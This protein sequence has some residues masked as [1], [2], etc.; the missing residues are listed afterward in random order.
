LLLFLRFLSGQIDAVMTPD[1]FEG[2][3]KPFQGKVLLHFDYRLFLFQVNP[4]TR[5]P[6]HPGKGGLDMGPTS[7]AGHP[8][9]VISMFHY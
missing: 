1:S 5:H 8:A 2:L 4:D 9:Y 6:F 3:L 7:H